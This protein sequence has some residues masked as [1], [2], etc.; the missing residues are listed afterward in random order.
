MYNA[1]CTWLVDR[2]GHRQGGLNG[3]GTGVAQSA[4]ASCVIDD[5]QRIV[6]WVGD[7]AELLGASAETVVGRTCYEVVHGRDPFG[8]PF[9]G[10]DCPAF[11]ALKDGSLS[12]THLLKA[13]RQGKSKAWLRCDLIALPRVPGG[14]LLRLSKSSPRQSSK[15]SL[16]PHASAGH[17]EEL[18]RDL[19]AQAVLSTSLSAD[20]LQETVDHSLDW[21]RQA[22][23][24]E[25]A[26]IFLSGPQ[27]EAV[28]LTA[29]R[30][31]FKAAFSQI[32]RFRIGEGF[33]GLVLKAGEPILTHELNADQHYLRARVKEKGFLSYVCVPL[34][35]MQ[36]VFGVLSVAS[37]RPDLDLEHALRIMTW[38]S[39]PITMALQT[40]LLQALQIESAVEGEVKQ[41]PEQ[42]FENLLRLHLRRLMKLGHATGGELLVYDAQNRALVRHVAEGIPTQLAGPNHD[43]SALESCPALA[44][45]EAICLYGPRRDWPAQCQPVRLRGSLIQCLPLVV[46]GHRLGVAVLQC[47]DQIPSPPSRHLAILLAAAEQVAQDIRQAWAN[48]QHYERAVAMIDQWK[49]ER[50]ED[51]GSV[52][53]APADRASEPDS[54]E[55]SPR[56][57]LLDIRCLGAFEIYRRNQLMPPEMFPRRDALTLLK[58]LLLH[59]GRPVPYD[60]LAEMLKPEADPELA[61]NRLHV[62]VHTLR[63]LLEPSAQRPWLFIRNRGG[64][65]YFNRDA[66]YRLDLQAF[67]DSAELGERL[68]G[69][70][71]GAK[72]I[73]AF[74]MAIS[75]Y[76]GD[77]FEDDPYAAWCWEDREVL[78]EGYLD[79]LDRLAGLYLEQ[80]VRERTIEL[81][82]RALKT[83]AL[84][85]R[86]H[87]KLIEAL[88]LEGRPAEALRQYEVCRDIL[89]RELRTTPCP[90]IEQLARNIRNSAY[91]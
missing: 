47:A 70:G 36:R 44:R 27:G 15:A 66:P 78:R 64:G 56:H 81:S 60:Q 32:T 10:R 89:Q 14:A 67:L 37:R 20:D 12:S 91:P 9:C 90:E 24:A 88:W 26:E 35:G 59:R 71:R 73:D 31:P 80:G 62:L 68:Q 83:D 86:M 48:L 65:Y 21:L 7:T 8:H 13:D 6:E 79:A 28:F 25:V 17:F 3:A 30:G 34:G 75:L 63:Q 46:Q 87:L 22:T 2:V 82:R 49:Q 53:G 11:Q 33:P 42:A 51:I 57:P 23:G 43:G 58:I 1:R 16:L 74:E 39:Q 84:R 4:E 52:R 69:K 38:A 29:F 72:A 5:R 45:C 61:V 54:L 41:N 55:A 77:L 50:A 19:A 18:I 85:E 40:A 76:R